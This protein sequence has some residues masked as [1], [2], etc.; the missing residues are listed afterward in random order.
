MR[1]RAIVAALA[2]ASWFAG[3]ASTAQGCSSD[4]GS[5][6][7][8][9]AAVPLGAGQAIGTPCDPSLPAPCAPLTDVCSVAVCDPTSDRCIRVPVEA[10]PTCGDGV[11]PGCGSGE[12][13]GGE[14]A[15]DA[16]LDSAPSEAGEAG[17]AASDGSIDGA[18]ADASD[19]AN[20]ASLD[21]GDAEAAGDAGGE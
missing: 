8:V 9:D 10:G 2:I 4:A 5:T 17:D 12:C 19:G 3:L 15:G 21:A 13:D 16:Q 11:P 6:G 14:E 7:G 20:D 1:A 18:S